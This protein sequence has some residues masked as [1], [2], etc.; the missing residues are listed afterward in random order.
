MSCTCVILAGGA[1]IRMREDKA[2]LFDNVNQLNRQLTDLGFTT[3]IACGNKKRADLFEGACVPDPPDA[4][5]LSDIIRFF[6][7]STEE[8]I[9]FFPCDMYLLSEESLQSILDQRP[10]I[11]VDHNGR[12]Q[13]TLA[14]TPSEWT[15]STQ[16][17]LRE[18]FAAFP[19]N[20]MGKHGNDL[21][22]F[23]HPE[24]LEVL[25]KLNR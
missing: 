23:N 7:N 19:R 20:D 9:Q 22:N 14:R 5:T 8:E 6:V 11:P 15:P 18:L 13:Y 4:N 17:T 16:S 25:S 1:S 3:I 21:M 2:L 10:G 24:Q 12:E